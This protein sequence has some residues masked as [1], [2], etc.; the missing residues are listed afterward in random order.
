MGAIEL[1]MATDPSSET[2]LADSIAA[3]ASGPK[4]IAV[5]G[6][7]QSSEHSLTDQIAAAKFLPPSRVRSRIGGGIRF[8]KMAN[9]GAA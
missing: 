5:E 8:G 9:G 1:G 4:H 2:T 7:G 6:M 3:S